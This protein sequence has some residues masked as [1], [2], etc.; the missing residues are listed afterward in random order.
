MWDT[1]HKLIQKG[2][3]SN[4]EL[5]R[6]AVRRYDQDHVRDIPSESRSTR[7]LF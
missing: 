6:I 2:R 1:L 4:K 7:M 5:Q 3:L